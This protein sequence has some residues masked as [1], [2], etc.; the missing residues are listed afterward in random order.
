MALRVT[1]VGRLGS[2]AG[3][4]VFDLG[5][6][7]NVEILGTTKASILGQRSTLYK[8]PFGLPLRG[9]TCGSRIQST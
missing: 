7:F 9:Y 2:R 6:S 4:Q 8:L 5:G 1:G 3:G